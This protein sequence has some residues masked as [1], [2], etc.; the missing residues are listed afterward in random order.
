MKRIIKMLLAPFAVLSLAIGASLSIVNRGV[1]EFEVK[2]AELSVAT[3]TFPDDNSSNNK[4]Q[5]YTSTKDYKIGSHTW[6]IFAF[7]NNNWNS[8]DF[9]RAGS[10][11]NATKPYI[12]TKDA[13][14]EAITKVEVGV[15]KVTASLVNSAD[16]LVSSDPNFVND[17][18]TYSSQEIAAGVMTYVVTSP[19][20]NKYYK[21]AYDLQK[22]TGNGFLEIN[23]VEYFASDNPGEPSVIITTSPQRIDIGATHQ[24][25][26]TV[27]NADDAIVNWSIE[28]ETVATID[29]TGLVT[30]VA[31]GEAIITASITVDGVDYSATSSVT[32]NPAIEHAG[33]LED[34]FTVQD[35]ILKA[36]Q[37]G[38][39]ATEDSYYIKGII[40]NVK[41]VDTGQ[42]GNAEFEIKDSLTDT[43][44]FL[45]YRAFAD[46][47]GAAFTNETAKEIQVGYEVI[48]YGKIVNY[49]SNTPETVQGTKN[50]SNT[51][52]VS[53]VDKT[54]ATLDATNFARGFNESLSGICDQD[55]NTNFD[56]LQTEWNNQEALF[57]NLTEGAQYIIIKSLE[58]E[59]GTELEKSIAKYTYI[60]NKY[61]SLNNYLGLA[62]VDASGMNRLGGRTSTSNVIAIV[63]ISVLS[64]TAM[65]GFYILNKKKSYK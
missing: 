52:H 51:T 38:E 4:V 43:K 18:V 60:A 34:P 27:L 7:N 49:K 14:P 31:A 62:S 54:Q 16:L 6:S 39:T 30:G 8:W 65:I 3:L 2:A 15:T 61:P 10:K 55:G 11:N 22:G 9:I 36:E 63:S 33:T 50:V 25:D 20:P 57:N 12:E 42:Y 40:S 64:L 48:V 28:P 5:N 24:Y 19:Q 13:Y 53:S 1:D 45:V 41:S 58:N 47:T 21:L 46:N 35:A 44:S 56:A 17:V 29:N 59:A 26:A 37:T 32:V 23:R